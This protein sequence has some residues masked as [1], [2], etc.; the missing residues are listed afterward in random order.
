MTDPQLIYVNVYALPIAKLW[1]FISADL[2]HTSKLFL[3]NV[4][5][6]TRVYIIIFTCM[7]WTFSSN[8]CEKWAASALLCTTG[9]GYCEHHWWPRQCPPLPWL[10]IHRAWG[11]KLGLKS[12]YRPCAWKMA[13]LWFKLC[14]FTNVRSDTCSKRF[15]ETFSYMWWLRHGGSFGYRVL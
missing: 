6:I 4:A 3:N 7:R 5:L 14:F 11:V 12:P 10:Y 9:A 15:S 2:A 13:E 8:G 1:G